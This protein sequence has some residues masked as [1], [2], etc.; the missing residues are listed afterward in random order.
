MARDSIKWSTFRTREPNPHP[1][2]PMSQSILER[3]LESSTLLDSIVQNEPIARF[4]RGYLFLNIDELKRFA[5]YFLNVPDEVVLQYLQDFEEIDSEKINT[6]PSFE[7][8]KFITGISW[9]AISTIAHGFL[10]KRRRPD[11]PAV[12][13]IS[14]LSLQSHIKIHQEYLTK[15]VSAHVLF[16][17]LAEVYAVGVERYLPGAP[18]RRG[19]QNIISKGTH[20]KTSEMAEWAARLKDFEDREAFIEQFGHRC[21]REMEISVPRWHDDPSTLSDS[22]SDRGRIS[23]T[24]GERAGVLTKLA[25]LG[26]YPGS[27]LERLR[28]N[29][30]NEWLKSYAYLRDLLVEVEKRAMD[31]G[32]L[33]EKQ[34]IFYL[35]QSTACELLDEPPSRQYLRKTVSQERYRRK[36]NRRYNPPLFADDEFNPVQSNQC[37]QNEGDGV[38]HGHGVS[39]GSVTGRVIT[40]ESP[41]EVEIN[42]NAGPRILVTEFT[43]A[44]WTPL[45]FQIDGLVMERGSL[46]SH[47]SIVAREAGIP[48]VVNVSNV[49]SK[50]KTGDL[51][52][53]DAEEGVVELSTETVARR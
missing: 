24:N 11:Q 3:G 33:T 41:Y 20:S 47:G 16:S 37:P 49:L 40:A 15:S 34:D 35:S 31:R 18:S 23:D 28:E 4:H 45:F 22:V 29:P 19:I 50:V 43:D 12:S 32:Y 9:S 39:Q 2:T 38:L 42:D 1:Y 53:V 26:L 52:K 17:A 10:T 13:G 44:G 14:D 36:Q 27:V 48:A 51:V 8:L 21:P 46:L 6:S 25:H 5:R 30:K 7:G